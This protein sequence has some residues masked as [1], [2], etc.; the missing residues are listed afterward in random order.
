MDRSTMPLFPEGEIWNL[1]MHHFHNSFGLQMLVAGD[2]A[3]FLSWVGAEGLG[4]GIETLQFTLL[5][6]LSGFECL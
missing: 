6:T 5:T 4:E 3:H 1:V 2:I